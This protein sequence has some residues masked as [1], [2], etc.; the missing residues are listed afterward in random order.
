MGI[1]INNIEYRIIEISQEEYKWFRKEEYKKMDSEDND[2]DKGIFFGASHH[3]SN[4]IF[5]DKNLPVDRKR[6]TLLHELAHCYIN[7][8][9][10]HEEKTYNEEDVSDIVANSFDIIKNIVDQY[11]TT[12]Y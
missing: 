7:E 6:K 3:Y 5:L 12:S 2:T 4:I 1:E 11:F 9:I 10:T 8:Y